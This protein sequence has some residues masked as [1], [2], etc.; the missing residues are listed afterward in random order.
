MYNLIFIA[1]QTVLGS[2]NTLPLCNQ[3][4]KEH[5]IF[6]ITGPSIKPSPEIEK[7]VEIQLK[8]T[9][10]YQCLKIDNKPKI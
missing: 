7:A 9:N 4:M 8:Y 1:T 5:A 2:F 3:A 6:A 10:K